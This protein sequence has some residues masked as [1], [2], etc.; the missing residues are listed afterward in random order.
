M[1]I[2]KKL[3]SVEAPIF[4]G[5]IDT[6]REA[7]NGLSI[8]EAIEKGLI[9]DLGDDEGKFFFK[10]ADDE[11]DAYYGI[12]NGYTVRL[13]DG[14]VDSIDNIDDILGKLRFTLGTSNVEGAGKG[15]T[16]FRLG[17]PKGIRLGESVKSLEAAQFEA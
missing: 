2:G 4:E 16:Y 10:H 6:M 11:I 12:V 8:N 15:M 14:L 9:T 5:M 7:L 3:K 17:L 1:K 13:S